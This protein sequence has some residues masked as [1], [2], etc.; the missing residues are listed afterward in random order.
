MGIAWLEKELQAGQRPSDEELVR[1]TTE[2]L[3]IFYNA[4]PRPRFELWCKVIA[5]HS[6][7]DY[8]HYKSQKRSGMD[9]SDLGAYPCFEVSVGHVDVAVSDLLKT[10]APPLADQIRASIQRFKSQP[11][12]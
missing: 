5:A 10:I 4:Y 3:E 7:R 12:E 6:D 9:K 2:E 8:Y 11:A 1:S